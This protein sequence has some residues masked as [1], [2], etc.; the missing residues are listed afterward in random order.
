[1]VMNDK[2]KLIINNITKIIIKI[3]FARPPQTDEDEK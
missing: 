3:K 2:H 1:M